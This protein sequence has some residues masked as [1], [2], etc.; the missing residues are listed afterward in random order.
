MYR[1]YC[2]PRKRVCQ[3]N[4]RSEKA[5]VCVDPCVEREHGFAKEREGE[6]ERKHRV[7]ATI[8]P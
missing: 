5:R 2:V 6:K 8:R 7:S 3:E 4:E 1:L